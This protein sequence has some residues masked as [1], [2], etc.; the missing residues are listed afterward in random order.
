MIGKEDVVKMWWELPFWYFMVHI[1]TECFEAEKIGGLSQRIS[2]AGVELNTARL[3]YSTGTF[4]M[5]PSLE[6]VMI[7]AMKYNYAA[8]KPPFHYTALTTI[9]DFFQVGQ[10]W[11]KIKPIWTQYDVTTL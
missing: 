4:A 1:L 7:Q 8:V 9:W 2:H 6:T 10:D 11:V 3:L 5:A